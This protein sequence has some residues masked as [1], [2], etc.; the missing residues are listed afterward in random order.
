M[1]WFQSTTRKGVKGKHKAESWQKNIFSNVPLKPTQNVKSLRILSNFRS[2]FLNLS[3]NLQLALNVPTCF[4]SKNFVLFAK[5]TSHKTILN[6][7]VRQSALCSLALDPNLLSLK[8][9][10]MSLFIVT[11]FYNKSSL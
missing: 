5:T 1:E 4:A 8:T 11:C 3:D 7:F 9:L 6:R 2:T 10:A